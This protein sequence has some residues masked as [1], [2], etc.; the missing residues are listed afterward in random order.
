M[1]APSSTIVATRVSSPKMLPN[2][3]S[4]RLTGLIS[5]PTTCRGK[6]SQTSAHSTTD[7]GEPARWNR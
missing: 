3:R 6:N 4:D 2:S 5:S 1:P 7:R